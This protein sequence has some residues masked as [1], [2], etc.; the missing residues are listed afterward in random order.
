[1]MDHSYSPIKI[2]LLGPFGFGNLGDAAIQQAMIE[3]IGKRYPDAEV[4]GFSLNPEDTEKRHGIKSFPITRMPRKIWDE[5]QGWGYR[6]RLA[7]LSLRLESNV[8]TRLVY[9]ILFRVPSEIV[10]IF[11]SMKNLQG[12][13]YLIV[14]GGGQLDDYWGGAWGH[15]Y[16]LFK[17]AILA[18]LLRVRFLVVSVGAGPLRSFLSKLFVKSALSL[19]SYRSFRDEDSKSFIKNIGFDH[20][21]YV[22]PDLA[23]SLQARN[24]HKTKERSPLTV[25]IG[26]MSYFDSRVWPEKDNEVYRGYLD[27]LAQFVSRIIKQNHRVVFFPGEAVHDMPVIDDLRKVLDEK[28]VRMKKNQLEVAAA[29]TVDTLTDVLSHCDVLVASRYHGVLLAQ[30]LHRPVIALSYHKKIEALMADAGQSKY[31]LDI[32]GFNVE[33]LVERFENLV[34]DRKNVEMILT[35]KAREFRA[36]L[37]QQYDKILGS[38]GKSRISQV[39]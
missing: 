13:D 22:Y 7:R 6:S 33:T 36:L 27:R 19:A 34:A 12:L 20:W 18:R 15:P 11:K 32:N 37:D 26:P 25:G 8:F 30:L 2:G 24:G 23:L 16:V 3:N 4:Y 17:W 21:G 39:A 9:R 5:G 31:C 38:N 14:S 29:T 10:L 28:R 1:M 35:N